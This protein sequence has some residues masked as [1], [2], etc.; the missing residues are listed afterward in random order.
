MSVRTAYLAPSLISPIATPATAPRIGTRRRIGR[1]IRRTPTPWRK[2]HSTR[3]RPR[4]HGSCTETRRTPAGRRAVRARQQAGID[5]DRA[6]YG[7]RPPV[8]SM[9]TLQDLRPKLMILDVAEQHVKLLG[10]IREIHQ[11]FLG[12][13]ALCALHRINARVLVD[14]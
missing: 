14:L 13:L 8:D 10:A 5:A 6:N 2:S 9:P 7:W 12:E 4:R 1:A 3:A 11:Q